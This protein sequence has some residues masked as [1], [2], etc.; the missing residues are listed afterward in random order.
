NRL[1]IL[2]ERPRPSFDFGIQSP[3]SN[4]RAVRSAARAHAAH[5]SA[6]KRPAKA[7]RA[8]PRAFPRIARS[9]S[10]AEKVRA[11]RPANFQKLPPFLSRRS[12]QL[13]AILVATFSPAL[14]EMRT[15]DAA[16]HQK[17]NHRVS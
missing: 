6:A 15:A 2:I 4:R 3:T 9:T 11:L 12:A 16:L 5:V 14:N 7:A 8:K 1:S 13:V 10:A 17:R